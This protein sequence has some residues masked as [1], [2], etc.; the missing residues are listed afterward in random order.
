MFVSGHLKNGTTCVI[1][2]VSAIFV[3][4]KISTD[5]LN[6]IKKK[7]GIGRSYRYNTNPLFDNGYNYCRSETN[8]ASQT[9]SAGITI[10]GLFQLSKTELK[11]LFNKNVDLSGHFESEQFMEPLD[12][13]SGG[14][15]FSQ[16]ISSRLGAPSQSR[17]PLK[18]PHKPCKKM[19]A[20]SSFVTHFKHEHQDI[21]KYTIQ[22]GKELWLPCNSSEIEHNSQYCLAMITVYENNRIDVQMSKSSQSVIKTCSKF[23]QQVPISSFWL[24]VSGSSEKNPNAAYAL[25]WLLTTSEEHYQSTIELSSKNDAISFSTYCG[26]SNSPQNNTFNDIAENLSCLIL[27]HASLGALLKE[28]PEINL[29]ITIH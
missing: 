3:Q 18:C 10:E 8:A 28:G 6:K 9:N 11:K 13:V 5:F 24:M 27:S 1:C 15:D 14:K 20:L 16:L 4:S 21:P 2:K 12:F 26:V 17:M 25:Y 22:R 29:R 23:T 7:P 19:V